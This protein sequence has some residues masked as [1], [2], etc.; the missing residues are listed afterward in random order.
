MQPYSQLIAP[1]AP[2]LHDRELYAAHLHYRGISFIISIG[3]Q[4]SGTM[5]YLHI[6]LHHENHVEKHA[7]VSEP[8][9]DGISSNAGPVCLQGS[10][11]EKLRNR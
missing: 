7:Y 3:I 1:E 9:L 2:H 6:V 10:I 8:K 4:I 11:D 5:R